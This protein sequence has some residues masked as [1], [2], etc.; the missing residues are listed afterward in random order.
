MKKANTIL[1][2]LVIV[3]SFDAVSQ[4]T[5]S[6][7]VTDNENNPVIGA[8]V[9]IVDTE[10][11]SI[12]DV[13]GKFLIDNVPESA[14]EIQI[15]YIGFQTQVIPI[16]ENEI[17][18]QLTEDDL[19][20]DEVVV[21]AFGISR[22]K[23]SLGYAVSEI[24]GDE[25]QANAEPD[26]LRSLQGKLAGASITGSNGAPGS[27]TRINLRG[28]TTIGS[29]DNQPLIIVD[30][31]PFSNDR[32]T[33]SYDF[34]TGSVG[35]AELG[36]ASFG[37]GLS[38][39]DPNNV[40]SIEVLKGIA[41]SA[42]YGERA[43]GGVILITTKSG[44]T[45]LGK[46]P[47]S[48]S[49]RQSLTIETIADLPEYQNLYGN[50]VNFSY[51]NANGS[52]GPAFASLDS[53]PT[54]PVYL[55]AFPELGAMYPYE[56]HPDNV[57]SLFRTGISPESSVTVDF[58]GEKASF[59]ATAS[60]LD[61]EGYIPNHYFKRTGISV[62]GTVKLAN[63]LTM[64]SKV[65]FSKNVT[66]GGLQG[67]NQFG[68][69]ATSFARALWLGRTWDATLPYTHPENGTPLTWN[70]AVGGLPQFDHPLWSW[71]NNFTDDE[72]DRI[73]ANLGFGLKPTDWLDV[74]YKF[75]INTYNLNRQF[76]LELGSRGNGGLGQFT[77]DII[78]TEEINSN[79]F[80]TFNK[81]FFNDKLD[82]KLILGYEVVQEKFSRDATEGKNFILPNIYTIANTSASNRTTI[83]SNSQRRLY[84]T[85]GDL[86]IGYDDM[87]YV[88]VTGRNDWSSTLPA[89]NN[90][91]F[92]PAASI[93][94]NP[95]RTF[96][97]PN[98]MRAKLRVA[99]GKVGRSVTPEILSFYYP[100]ITTP[101]NGQPAQTVGGT[102]P[103]A[104]L[105]PEFTTEIEV[106]AEFNYNGLVGF[107]L[108]RF[109]R[110]STDIQIFSPLPASSGASSFFTNAASIETD[111]WEFA[112]DYSPFLDSD[113]PV[114]WNGLFT[115][116][117]YESIVTKTA[118]GVERIRMGGQ[119]GNPSAYAE[120]G[121][122]AGYLRGSVN[123]RDDEGNL[124]INR[125][126]GLLV[127]DPQTAMIG[128]PTPDFTMGFSNTLTW[129]NF[130]LGAV[131]SYRKGGDFYSNS[132][133]S[134]LGK[135]VTKDTEDRLHSYIIE[136]VYGTPNGP[137]LDENGNK[138]PARVQVSE[139]D[140][141]FGESFA[142]NAADEWNVYDA[143]T[144]RLNEVSLGYNLPESLF[145][146]I[147]I[148]GASIN[149]VGR[150]LWFF[151]PNIPKYTNFDPETNA[152][153]NSNVQG[154]ELTNAPNS[155]RLGF[156]LNVKF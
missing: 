5:V 68:G 146:N 53:I 116:Y 147:P 73:G 92:Y 136:G 142:I 8:T 18:V 31:V 121:M 93:S 128:D 156:N 78:R 39:L 57:S 27:S 2:L 64:D 6:G 149:V 77:Q 88:N 59:A 127:R 104:E 85:Y 60:H 20:L 143:T 32:F 140:L 148:K 70:G 91:F 109:E 1:L 35:N 45:K 107:E 82:A 123:L 22:E 138:I 51:A 113:F 62:G 99:Y 17:I 131:F 115:Y 55:A 86:S 141:Y 29:G 7:T 4:T 81:L 49:V 48:I 75:G 94:F 14:S 117:T 72:S 155:K 10:L 36:S 119:S 89:D 76:R 38:S 65:F 37:S 33:T 83:N 87:V 9:R 153:G 25:V 23:R 97:L 52:W 137:T 100:L 103:S 28:I 15:S 34:S 151:A 63:A 30:G 120:V 47:V 40:E 125:A 110:E 114:K 79:L 145:G 58:G 90:S 44:S 105:T 144:I 139:N 150:N 130:N 66:R 56:A 122:P 74:N 96:N 21:T 12:T 54:W 133:S 16:Q 42:L 61:Q 13:E 134:L 118:E 67:N 129:K 41:A 46:R 26:V 154:I 43:A 152:F 106:G 135:G 108:N 132:I 101:I 84:G 24:D 19:L 95:I 71:E 3:L 98:T 11:G 69:S 102:L 124:L 50:G 80:T 112:L 111:G 126:T